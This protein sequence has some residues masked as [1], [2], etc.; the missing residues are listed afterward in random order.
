MDY[1]FACCFSLNSIPDISKWDFSSIISFDNM[2]YECNSLSSLP[3]I[4]KWKMKK[5]NKFLL[6]IKRCYSLAYMPGIF[7]CENFDVNY[8]SKHY[9]HNDL[10]NCL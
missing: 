9:V 4:E 7:E 3:H 6:I 1:L 10:I 5:K 2:F 8:K